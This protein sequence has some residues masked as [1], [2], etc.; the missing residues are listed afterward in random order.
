M[1]DNGNVVV[2]VEERHWKCGGGNGRDN[3]N[4]VGALQER[5]WKCGGGSGGGGGVGKAMER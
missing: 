2:V 5:Q 3:E 1:K 4:V